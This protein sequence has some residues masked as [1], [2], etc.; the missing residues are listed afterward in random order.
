[1]SIGDRHFSYAITSASGNRLF[2]LGY[3]AGNKPD[4]EFLAG[5]PAAEPLLNQSFS[6][7]KTEFQF[8]HCILIPEAFSEHKESS[9]ELLKAMT[10]AFNPAQILSDVIGR[11]QIHAV[12]AVPRPLYWWL[13]S[14]FQA[15]QYRHHF[16]AVLQSGN[17]SGEDSCFIIDFRPQEF[18]VVVVKENQVVLA[19]TYSYSTPDDVLFRLLK[20]CSFF[21]LEQE[22]VQI[23][24]SGLIEE[25]SALYHELFQYFLHT[26]FRTCPE[27][28]ETLQQYGYPSQYFVSLKDLATCAL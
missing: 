24:L 26:A 6:E 7:V 5:L 2:S 9:G 14:K 11:H 19:Q 10:G 22:Q 4:S 12:F 23:K 18:S 20:I 27:W 8:S 28:E 3:Y 21:G 15:F 25:Q 17:F 1:M 13:T 16:S